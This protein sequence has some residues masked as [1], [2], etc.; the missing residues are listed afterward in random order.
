MVH[1][2][3]KS[4]GDTR[5]IES[6]SFAFGKKD[7]FILLGLNGAGK[8]TTFRCLTAEEKPSGGVIKINDKPIGDYFENPRQLQNL[9]G[10]C[11]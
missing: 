6:I 4:Y 11:P 3:Q 9:M 10:Y 7:R 5:A 2:L 8:S 1:N